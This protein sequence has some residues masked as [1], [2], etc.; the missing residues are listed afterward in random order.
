MMYTRCMLRYIQIPHRMKLHPPMPVRRNAGG[1]EK[2]PEARAD[3]PCFGVEGG[4]PPCL[5]KCLKRR[6]QR[7]DLKVA[8][9]LLTPLEKK[10]GPQCW[11]TP[12]AHEVLHQLLAE[13]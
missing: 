12:K 5:G 10:P 7:M 8:G 1:G 11:D 13:A 2:K 9:F 4:V 6:A 3:V